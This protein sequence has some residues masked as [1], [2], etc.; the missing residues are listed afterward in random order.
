MSP[1]F[2][3]RLRALAE[4]LVRIGVNLQPKQSLLITEPYELHGV[5]PEAGPLVEAVRTA[6]AGHEVTAILADPARLRALV[7]ADDRRGFEGLVCGHIRRL[8]LHRANGGA[9]LFLQGSQP[10]LLAGLP[11]ERLAAFDRIKW[12]HLGPFIQRLVGGAAQWTL[13]PAPSMAWADAAYADLPAAKRLPALWRTVFEALRVGLALDAVLSS[14]RGLSTSDSPTFEPVV[15]WSTHL[16]ALARR[17]DEL[18]AAR[19]RRI[20][21][22]GPGTDLTLDLPRSHVWCTAQLVSRG[23][24]S[25]VANLPTEEVFTAPHKNSAHG[26]LRIA[27]P[28]VHGGAVIEGIELEF[29]RGRVVAANARTGQDVLQHLLA[30]DDGAGRIGAVAFVPAFMEGPSPDGPGPVGDRP[31]PWQTSGRLFH[32]TLLDENSTHHIALGEAYRFCSRALFPLALNRSQVHLDLPL[33][34]TVELS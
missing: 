22:T 11:A 21:Y 2:D 30:T 29:R 4:V 12:R 31:Y 9:F 28:V 24:I 1:D 18:N 23:G 32:H 33:D 34:A 13:A 5:H 14:A 10:Q 27:R 16:A 8:E 15:L 6:A 7:E 26:T 25:F 17:R 3:A 19:H 20:S